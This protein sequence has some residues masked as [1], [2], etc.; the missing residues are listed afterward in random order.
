MDAKIATVLA[1]LAALLAAGAATPAAAY[2][3]DFE[4][5]GLT[6]GGVACG[7]AEPSICAGFGEGEATVA[8]QWTLTVR[9]S[10]PYTTKDY[11]SPGPLHAWA[12]GGP[13]EQ[14]WTSTCTWATLYATVN[15][16]KHTVHANPMGIC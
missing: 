1:S 12:G 6:G 7:H 4:C 5:V 10:N 11:N 8:V 15:G 9:T 3:P 16:V 14:C 2:R 13:S